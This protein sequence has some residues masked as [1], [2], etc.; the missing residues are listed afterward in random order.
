MFDKFIFVFVWEWGL[1]TLPPLRPS[2]ASYRTSAD[3]DLVAAALLQDSANAAVFNLD[4]YLDVVQAL[5]GNAMTVVLEGDVL[6]ASGDTTTASAA[7]AAA[8]RAARATRS[9]SA[10]T[11]LT[12]G[13]DVGSGLFPIVS[14]FNHSSEP[15]ARVLFEH[16]F[17]AKA[18]TLSAVE[19][20]EECTI[21]YVPVGNMPGAMSDEEARNFFRAY[22][23]FDPDGSGGKATK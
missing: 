12:S 23:G 13:V 15:N 2:P 11:P 19:P 17:V 18:V 7:A 4:W 22:Y 1:L 5:N 10:A 20:G 14:F 8:A 3:Y 9:V 21:A 6:P 16:D